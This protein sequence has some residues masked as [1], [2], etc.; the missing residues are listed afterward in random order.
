MSVCVVF[1]CT[2][3][4]ITEYFKLEGSHKDHLVPLTEY[5]YISITEVISG[6]IVLFIIAF[7]FYKRNLNEWKGR[8]LAG[9]VF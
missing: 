7:I 9:C 5:M 1:V 4:Y 6:F 3:V 2:C 8:V